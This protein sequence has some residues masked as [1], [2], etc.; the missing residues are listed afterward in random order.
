M[1][2][3]QALRTFKEVR[4]VQE[5][6][7]QEGN[8]TRQSAMRKQDYISIVMR[9]GITAGELCHEVSQLPL[10]CDDYPVVAREVDCNGQ[11][12][13]YDGICECEKVPV[14]DSSGACCL[15]LYDEADPLASFLDLKLKD[16]KSALQDCDPNSRMFF[17][18]E[19]YHSDCFMF[20]DAKV[21]IGVHPQVRQKMVILNL[22]PESFRRIDRQG[23]EE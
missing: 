16:L 3:L 9:K 12:N 8:I 4:A 22:D 21:T 2:Q 7:R 10:E 6:L 19:D 17:L 1:R 18:S 11:D 20:S 15:C 14:D 23:D 5:W 13:Y